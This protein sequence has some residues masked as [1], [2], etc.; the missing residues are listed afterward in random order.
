MGVGDSASDTRNRLWAALESKKEVPVEK[1]QNP[2]GERAT[3]PFTLPSS[4]PFSA[5]RA[6]NAGRQG[7]V[8]G[9]KSTFDSQRKTP[10][11]DLAPMRLTPAIGRTIDIVP[12]KGTDLAT[13][14]RRLARKLK[15]NNVRLQLAQQRFHER[16]GLR[17]KRLKSE[18]WRKRFLK[19]FLATIEQV[20]HMRKQGW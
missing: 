10:R 7:R 19:G 6:A 4:S 5:V 18:R 20:R 13:G 9:A 2:F 12:E 11:Q 3:S 8:A 15:D 1:M 17:R 16:P 14:L